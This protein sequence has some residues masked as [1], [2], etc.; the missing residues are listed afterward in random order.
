MAPQSSEEIN[1][2]NNDD[3]ATIISEKSVTPSEKDSSVVDQPQ[4]SNEKQSWTQKYPRLE[5]LRI[6]GIFVGI[7]LSMFVM[8]LNSTVVAPAMS[9]IATQ[10]HKLELQAWIATSFMVAMISFQ[11]LAG[12]FSDI[13]GRKPVLMFGLCF[14]WIGSLICS[15]SPSME[16]VI[17]GRTIQGFGAGGIFSM[18]FV[19]VTD[20]ASPEWKPRLQSM[21][22]V[23][24]GLSSVVGPLIGGAFVDH[25]S[26]RWDFYINIIIA[27]ISILLLFFLFQESTRVQ[28]ES[29]MV[30][31]KRIDFLGILFS[32]SCVTCLLLA[33]GWGPSYGWN[34]AHSIGPFVAAGVAFI[35]LIISQGWISKEPVMPVAIMLKP[36]VFT[37][38]IYMIT[39]GLGF[40]GTLYF[41]PILF[42]SVFGANST[43]SG[44]RLIPFM[45][46]LI[47]GS[48][49]S[50]ILINK[51]PYF[52]IYLLI[53][54]CSNVL[55]YGLFFTVNENSSWGQQAGYLSFCGLAFGLSQ[56][57]AILA[58]QTA[59]GKPYMAVAT[60]LTNFFMML[61]SAIGIAI[62][63]TLFSVFLKNQMIE[64]S[65]QEPDIFAIAN[66]IG[67]TSNYL[68]IRNMPA[69][70]QEPVI[71]AYMKSLHLVF[72]VPL[73]A[74]GISVIAAIFTRNVRFGT[75]SESEEKKQDEQPPLGEVIIDGEDDKDVSSFDT[76]IHEENDRS[77]VREKKQ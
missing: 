37:V 16:G 6:V 76:S 11:P 63:Q 41:G 59:A 25:A 2:Q 35:L 56:Q 20:L 61:G 42:Q 14:F 64:L 36:S 39:L 71:K 13:F 8:S 12:K 24:Y 60:S 30:K 34:E 65:V 38:Y 40:V 68:Y 66:N 19:V 45:A 49:G 54:A 55:G 62:Y 29:F 69:D 67:A 72:I 3:A 33:L 52:K 77:H 9:I 46:C 70:T 53:G 73:C 15:T 58:V 23:I 75:P 50:S 26:W 51:F 32:I 47:A 28:Q 5:R 18:M 31:I 57:N 48:L 74:A 27:G 10:L 21:L 43:Q 22:T 17:A 44:V 7:V 4:Q 1:I